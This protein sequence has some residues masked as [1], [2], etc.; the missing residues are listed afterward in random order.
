M[1]YASALAYALFLLLFGVSYLQFRW[2][3]R[4][5]EI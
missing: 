1:G 2:Y 3:A 4:R 5:V